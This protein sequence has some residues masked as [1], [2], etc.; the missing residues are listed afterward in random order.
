MVV[1][2]S[3]VVGILGVLLLLSICLSILIIKKLGKIDSHNFR[4]V[5]IRRSVLGKL[6]NSDISLQEAETTILERE[7]FESC[8]ISV[9]E[10]GDQY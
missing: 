6:E 10:F 3:W 2:N 9:I 1:L 5:Q 8:T 4:S 7:V